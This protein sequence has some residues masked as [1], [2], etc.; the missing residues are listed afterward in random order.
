VTGPRSLRLWTVALWAVCLLAATGGL[1]DAGRQAG[2]A[3]AT[4]AAVGV[5]SATADSAIL[6]ARIADEVRVA[7][8][9]A[10]TRLL[11]LGAVLAVLVG[12]PAAAR[13]RASAAAALYR[14]LR[15]RRCT[16]ALRAPPL[17]FA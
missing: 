12:L 11:V 6:P 10:P 17:L 13:R 14:P 3:T 15:A 2:S 4:P 9:S 8:Q 1:V 5:L 7:A 16:I